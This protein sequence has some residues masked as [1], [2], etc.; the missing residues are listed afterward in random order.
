MVDLWLLSTMFDRK[1]RTGH[2]PTEINLKALGH[3][4]F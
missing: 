1:V 4:L 2:G 3:D